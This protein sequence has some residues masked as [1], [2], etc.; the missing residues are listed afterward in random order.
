MRTRLLVSGMIVAP[1]SQPHS[2]ACSNRLGLLKG[3]FPL[4]LRRGL[5][6]ETRWEKNLLA[7]PRLTKTPPQKP[8]LGGISRNTDEVGRCAQPAFGTAHPPAF[9]QGF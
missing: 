6:K 3:T 8:Y 5:F 4:S 2:A 1:G 9:A 7:T